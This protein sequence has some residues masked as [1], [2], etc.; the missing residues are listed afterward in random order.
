MEKFECDGNM[1]YISPKGKIL[2]ECFCE[3]N[4]VILK[5]V[6]KELYG[7]LDYKAMG[8]EQL[9]DFIKTVKNVELYSLAKESCLYAM[10]TFQEDK[11]F[12]NT[13]LAIFISS[14]RKLGCQREAIDIT[15]ACLKNGIG[16]TVAILTSLASAYLDIEN[17]DKA[18]KCANRAYFLQGGG[19]GETTELS[20]VYSRLRSLTG[21]D[22]NG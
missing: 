18:K 7:Q 16:D 9:A 21:D 13:I 22:F 3:V 5:K 8:K 12:I 6:G 10:R 17:Y 1:Y 14:C 2:D 20:L 11:Y 19:K 15:N 4:S